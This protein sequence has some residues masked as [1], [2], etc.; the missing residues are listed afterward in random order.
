MNKLLN[1]IFLGSVVVALLL[2]TSG[3]KKDEAP[4]NT[5]TL[6][7]ETNLMPLKNGN[8]CVY[9]AYDVDTTSANMVTPPPSA[10]VATKRAGSDYSVTAVYK[11]PFSKSGRSDAYYMISTYTIGLTTT[12][13]TEYVATDGNGNVFMFQLGQW[14]K[15]FDRAQGVNTGYTIGS[16][17]DSSLG[18][19]ITVTLKGTITKENVTV[20]AGTFTTYKLELIGY[21]YGTAVLYNYFW[22]A[23]D[24]G[25]VRLY[26]PALENPYTR[27][28]TVGNVSKLKSK[29][30]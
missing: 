23:N 29:N 15:A 7:P 16:L 9:D 12:I 13:D 24:V 10:D 6:I 14:I 30:F 11:G 26:T 27:T 18:I 21:V 5:D 17:T 19:A 2:L 4:T 20:P 3:C 28:R 8:F 1:L 25:V 22:L